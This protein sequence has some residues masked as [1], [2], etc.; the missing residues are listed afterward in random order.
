VES[1]AE[2]PCSQVTTVE[3]LLHQTLTSI[4]CNILHPVQV[5]LGKKNEKNPPRIPN[6]FLCAYLLFCVL[7]LQLLSQ[8][9]ADVTILQAEV[10]WA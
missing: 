3:Q 8:G 6:G 9:S 4:H 7:L 1:K 10:A 5:S 2:L